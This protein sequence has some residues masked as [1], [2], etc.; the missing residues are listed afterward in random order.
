MRA[1]GYGSSPEAGDPT[2]VSPIAAPDHCPLGA[3]RPV[4]H[5]VLSTFV[6][7]R[8]PGVSF[9][10]FA[11]QIPHI[12]SITKPYKSIKKTNNPTENQTKAVNRQLTEEK[13]KWLETYEKIPSREEGNT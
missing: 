2:S 12:Q 7:A 1:G 11:F 10:S 5:P 6:Q 8:R 9:N 3:P 4:N 13:N